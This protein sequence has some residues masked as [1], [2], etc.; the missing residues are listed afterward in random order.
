VQQSILIIDDSKLV[1]NSLSEAL[2]NRG[3]R[4]E[5]AFDVASAKVL[6]EEDFFDF[7]LLDLILP[8]GEGEM[9][10]PYLQAAGDTRVIVMTSDRDK[11]RRQ[12]LFSYGVVIDYIS[13]ER[14]F[15]DME[16]AIVQLIERI[17]QNSA[18][19]ILIVD[20]SNFLRNTLRIHLSKRGFKVID[21]IDGKAA[22]K[23]LQAQHVDAAM[24]DL[25]MPVM[26]GN[27]LLSAIRRNRK[28]LRLPVM[29]LSGTSDPDKIAHVIK[30]G[31]NDFI[32]KPYVTEELLLKV[33]KLIEELKLQRMTR[34]QEQRFSTYNRAIDDA[35]IFLKLDPSMQIS[36]CNTAFS[37]LFDCDDQKC[38]GQHI[39]KLI[40]PGEH[41]S[42][43]TMVP[44]LKKGET[45]QGVIS[46]QGLNGQTR[47]LRLTFSPILDHQM[48][49]EE[50]LAIGFDVT[51]LYEKE[52]QLQDRI[53]QEVKQNIEQNKLLIQ[54]SKMATMGEMIGHIGH[55]WRQPLN[56]LGLLFQK[57][58]LG[59]K[60]GR[61]SDEFVSATT[62]KALDVVDQMSI[63]IDDFRDF[64][65]SDKAFQ[66]CRLSEVY[67]Q[68]LGII[69][70]TFES[71][72]VSLQT[73]VRNDASLLCLK[74]ELA[75]VILN[76]LT[77]ALDALEER[78]V[79]RGEVKVILDATDTVA[80][81]Q[82]S[83]NAGGIEAGVQERIFEPYFTTKEASGGTGI[84]LYMSKMIVQK[85]MNG[86]LE[87]TNGDG[88][89]CFTV[90]LP[91][92]QPDSR[93]K[94]NG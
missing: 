51:L 22:L 85:H 89:A 5:Q 59:Y 16:L 31:A 21:A 4:V 55:Q 75:Q 11:Q 82:V 37:E 73:D 74:N 30:N 91:F 93:T 66:Q 28:H 32:K 69:G 62:A 45:K 17:S 81:I 29:V 7:A 49:L 46:F 65:R 24:I 23:I 3:Y 86:R 53:A 79:K 70:A 15:N 38:S 76:L 27:K 1:N 10:L 92:D 2:K 25:E 88:G 56:T 33:D 64:F 12:E 72:N 14:H 6:L 47:M 44:E 19:T 18:Y 58:R 60:K 78:E 68:A 61:L 94:E 20:D 83:D 77:N 40:V 8:D 54:Q 87:V 26:D 43:E 34:T 84:G 80:V 71:R 13:K 63:T 90:T 9:L 48:G 67:A 41:A 50:V 39:L 52:S 36:Y 42:F 35:A 57:L